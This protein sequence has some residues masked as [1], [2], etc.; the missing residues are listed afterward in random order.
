[1]TANVIIIIAVV[2]L[3][4]VVSWFIYNFYW[5]YTRIFSA[6][7]KNGFNAGKA[8]NSVKTDRIRELHKK[9]IEEF[10]L[11][12]YEDVEVSAFDNASLRGR[13]FPVEGS[14]NIIIVFHGYRSRVESDGSIVTKYCLDHGF[15][16]LAVHQRGHGLSGGKVMSFGV[17]ERFDCRT[18]ADFAVQRLGSDT[19]ILLM[20][21]S[22]GASTVMS[23][24]ELNIPNVKGIFADC[25][26][27][28]PRGMFEVI[29]SDM[30]FPVDFTYFFIR[31]SA[32]ILGGFDT[33]A[34]SA[35]K[36]LP[37]S[38]TPITIIHGECDKFV[39]CSM[40]KDCFNAAKAEKKKLIII[41]NATHAVSYFYDT[42]KY[43][44]A[45][46]DM[47]DLVSES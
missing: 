15:N 19:K 20:G 4:I 6:K 31:N 36:A 12:P 3:S 27:S 42:K 22:M 1:M 25:G 45:L 18:W 8:V 47:L 10:N 33:E 26:F 21:V 32:R 41:P 7:R 11:L 9:K 37:N 35:L 23:A 16:V 29:I 34:S 38:G 5:S 24:S 39:P 30:H 46:Q 13:F 14:S 28:S 43:E 40:A 2:L 44:T 17:L